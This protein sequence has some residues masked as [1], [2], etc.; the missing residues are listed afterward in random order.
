MIH[1][2]IVITGILLLV[3]ALLIFNYHRIWDQ[4]PYQSD[5]VNLPNPVKAVM[6]SVIIPARNEFSRIG[7]CLDSIFNQSY[8]KD[9]IEVIVVNDYSTDGTATLVLEHKLKCKLMNLSDFVSENLNS[10]KKKAIETGINFSS[11]ELIICT[12]ADCFMGADWIKSLVFTYEKEKLQCIAAPVKIIPDGSWLSVFQTLDFISLQGITGA[13]VYKNLYPM[14]NGANL[15]YTRKAYDIVGGFSDIDHIA[16]G[17]DMLLM[18]KIQAAFPGKIGYIKDQRAIVN[19]GPA[20]NIRA[21]FRQR[22]RWASKISHYKH[23]ATFLTLALVFLV[24]TCLLL[25]FISCFFYG[26]WRWLLILIV[27]K[28]ISEYF[29]VSKVAHFFQQ[30]SLMKYF[31]LCQP[32]HILYTV[33]AGSFGSFGKYEWKN[34]KVK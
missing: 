16:S 5:P 14:C 7:Y 33:I 22:I 15:A 11:G 27:F 26:H 24:N 30:Q 32:F 8:P 19:T 9:F 31:P 2:L 21:F 20:E 13:S 17:D 18:K 4:I 6:V 23:G 3:Y 25:L 29:F 10:Y 34:R 1:P 28:T 12:D